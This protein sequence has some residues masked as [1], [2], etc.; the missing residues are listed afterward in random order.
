MVTDLD[1][2]RG[3]PLVQL[4]LQENRGFTAG[5]RQ[6]SK[7]SAYAVSVSQRS[8][9][10]SRVS[11]KVFSLA[12]SASMDPS[13]RQLCKTSRKEL[14]RPRHS[15]CTSKVLRRCSCPA[16]TRVSRCLEQLLGA[17]SH[18]TLDSEESH[19]PPKRKNDNMTMNVC[20]QSCDADKTASRHVN[21]LVN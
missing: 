16:N 20:V 9:S 13:E 4:L 6:T 11:A 10:L 5:P 8:R 19:L 14:S 21:R 15:S 17:A 2:G 1:K 3:F 7:Q 18:A 12:L